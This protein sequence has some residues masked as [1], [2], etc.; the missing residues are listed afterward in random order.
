MSLFIFVFE[1]EMGYITLETSHIRP[2]STGEYKPF[3]LRARLQP[4]FPNHGNHAAYSFC[5]CFARLM[6]AL[7]SIAFVRSTI[8]PC[9]VS[10]HAPEVVG[11]L[12]VRTTEKR[13]LSQTRIQFEHC[14]KSSGACFRS[15]VFNIHS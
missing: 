8:V 12:G 9:F 2:N 14:G 11:G 6:S 4:C 5:E 13:T 3:I 15:L 7:N 1:N 10:R